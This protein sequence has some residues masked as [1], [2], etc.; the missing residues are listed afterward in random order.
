MKNSIFLL[1]LITSVIRGQSK[2]EKEY[3]LN[4]KEVPLKALSF[5]QK[6]E[7]K[8]RL[9]WYREEGSDGESIEA[10]F[11]I[12]KTKYSI[13]FDTIGKIEDIE[14]S[15]EL[16]ALE[17][18]LNSK[19]NKQLEKTFKKYKVV[20]TQKQLKGEE[21]ELIFYFQK[22]GKEFI[23]GYE[24]VVKGSTEKDVNLYELFFNEKGILTSQRKIII[25][26]SVHLE[27]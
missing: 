19:I 27:Y 4:E 9:K 21:Q 22:E 25:K 2:Y 15:I 26:S 3:R 7:N 16:S 12:A 1:L 5:I 13:E 10:K 18:T 6:V 17:V 8:K 20:K 23:S 14:E 11:K 24:L